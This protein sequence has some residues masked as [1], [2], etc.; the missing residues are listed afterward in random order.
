M[1]EALRRAEREWRQT[2]DPAAGERLAQARARERGVPVEWVRSTLALERL[3]V[4]AFE[5]AAR[6][7]A[8]ADP[9]GFGARAQALLRELTAGLPV[10]FWFLGW[11]GGP[12]PQDPWDEAAR[13]RWVER[14]VEQG[15]RAAAFWTGLTALGE[16]R[17]PGEPEALREHL[18]RTL[19]DVVD[20]VAEASLADDRWFADVPAAM[21]WVLTGW[22]EEPGARAA[23]EL[24][25]RWEP[26]LERHFSSWIAPAPEAVRG[27]A[28]EAALDL[29]RQRFRERYGDP[30]ARA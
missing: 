20:L 30:D 11:Q 10:G 14:L 8:E 19:E 26:L 1:D 22:G 21:R 3:D 16:A 27:F 4:P 25:D 12:R 29:L 23:D 7:A 13:A 9:P 24:G 6:A 5:A 15:R 17:P 2:G 28:E 18:Q